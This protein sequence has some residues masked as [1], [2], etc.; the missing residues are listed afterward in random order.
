[1]TAK[2]VESVESHEA[3]LTAPCIPQ[4]GGACCRECPLPFK[5]NPLHSTSLPQYTQDSMWKTV[6]AYPDDGP[7]KCNLTKMYDGSYACV[8]L[9]DV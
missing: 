8:I 1:M 3:A 2:L 4:D 5:D 9:G 6:Q 7:H